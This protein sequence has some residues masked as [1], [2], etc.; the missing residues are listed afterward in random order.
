MVPATDGRRVYIESA[1]GTLAAIDLAGSDLVWTRRIAVGEAPTSR[2]GVAVANWQGSIIDSPIVADDERLLIMDVYS[3]SGQPVLRCLDAR[4]GQQQWQAGPIEP[5]RRLVAGDRI[6]AIGQHALTAFGLA[7]GRELFTTAMPLNI[8]VSGRGF[9]TPR[10]AY[11]PTTGGILVVDLNTRKASVAQSFDDDV[12]PSVALVPLSS[13]LASNHGSHLKLFGRL[14]EYLDRVARGMAEHPGDPAW[15]R[16]MAELR[17][18]EKNF[19]EAERLLQQALAQADALTDPRRRG[20]EKLAT[21]DRLGR[22]QVTWARGLAAQGQ[23]TEAVERLMRVLD[24]TADEAASVRIR[25]MLADLHRRQGNRL[26]AGA[27][28]ARVAGSGI[29]DR[30]LVPTDHHGLEQSLGA[31]ALAALESLRQG[32]PPALPRGVARHDLGR[33]S[34]VRVGM[35]TWAGPSL[36]QVDEDHATAP[37][38]WSRPDGL[39]GMGAAG[40]VRWRQARVGYVTDGYETPVV[41]GG[42][43]FEC[44]RDNVLARR[45]GDGRVAWAWRVPAGRVTSEWAQQ[46]RLLPVRR[47][48]GMAII[49]G[50]RIRVFNPIE[51][52]RDR[53]A[54]V[55]SGRTIVTVS[56]LGNGNAPV[57]HGLDARTGELL[58]E[59]PLAP[60]GNVEHLAEGDGAVFVASQRRSGTLEV[61]CVDAAGGDLRWRANREPNA[62]SG[63]LFVGRGVLVQMDV[64][65]RPWV[66]D[67][68]SGKTL[69]RSDRQDRQ[70]PDAQVVY[71]D[72]DVTVSSFTEGHA[73]VS[74]VTGGVLWQIGSAP[75]ARQSMFIA[76]A[77]HMGAWNRQVVVGS[78]LVTWDADDDGGAVVA[79]RLGSGNVVWKHRPDEAMAAGCNFLLCNDMLIYHDVGDIAFRR[80][81]EAEVGRERGLHFLDPQSGKYLGAVELGAGSSRDGLHPQVEVYRVQGGLFVLNGDEMLVVRP[82]STGVVP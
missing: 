77:A 82:A 66:I 38:L 27:N 3:D 70:W 32:S 74:N 42:M 60:D 68:Q 11:L 37:V 6:L 73:V 19:A 36:A 62:H 63:G 26:D 10:A 72:R 69:W 59:L 25:M 12:P 47:V 51:Q 71:A 61:H 21:F 14:D 1:V 64:V 52:A 22:L 81:G 58:W 44:S 18:Q 40:E 54:L 43:F 79:R 35:L 5:C 56:Y 8:Q 30:I 31:Q 53:I 9:A 57:L 23:A 13:G 41:A 17:R 29:A 67:S 15:T 24:S 65:G 78:M 34:P 55:A 4:T 20:D 50:R 7:D 80:I 46:N 33:L 39:V 49:D 45:L 16:R 48:E 28:Y 75:A 76:G 2:G